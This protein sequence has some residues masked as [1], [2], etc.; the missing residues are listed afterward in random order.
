MSIKSHTL[1]TVTCEGPSCKRICPGAL[2]SKE[3]AKRAVEKGW[4]L[5]DG[6]DYCERCAEYGRER[7]KARE[8]MSHERLEQRLAEV[9]QQAVERI[10]RAPYTLQ[11]E[12]EIAGYACA[13]AILRCARFPVRYGDSSIMRELAFTY[14]QAALDFRTQARTARALRKQERAKLKGTV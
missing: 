11:L 8:L 7:A 9:R 13:R 10:R 5:H 14:L 2:S 3:A 1:Y 12:K 6:H 4:E